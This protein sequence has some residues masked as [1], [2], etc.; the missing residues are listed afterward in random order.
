MNTYNNMLK[1]AEKYSR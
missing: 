1:K